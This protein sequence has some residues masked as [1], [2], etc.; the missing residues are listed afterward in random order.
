MLCL[1]YL[2]LAE[3]DYWHY[4]LEA[5]FCEFRR[6]GKNYF[7][8]EADDESKIFQKIREIIVFECNAEDEEF[9]LFEIDW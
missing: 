7:S 5:D 9:I 2:Y 6:G 4:L 3:L 8:T 1:T